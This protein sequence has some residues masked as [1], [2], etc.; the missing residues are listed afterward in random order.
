VERLDEERWSDIHT[1]AYTGLRFDPATGIVEFDYLL[2][3]SGQS[4]SFTD[5]ITFPVPARLPEPDALVTFH[6]V[7]Q[8]LYV[9]VGTIYY[10]SVAPPAVELR[11]VRLTPAASRWAR[12]LY[13]QGLA[14]FAYRW[15]LPHVLELDLI[16]QSA[17]P[18]DHRRDLAVAGRAPLVA[19]GGGKDS[20]VSLEAMRAAGLRPATFA[21]QRQPT[22]LLS[23]LMALAGGPALLVNR[24]QDPRL[25]ALLR[26][27]SVRIGHVP[28]T[29]INS[30]I[31]AA[32]A[33]LHGLGPVVMSN[34]RSADEGNLRWQG[35]EVNHQWSKGEVAEALLRDALDEHAGLANGCFSLLRGM[36]ELHIAQ[37]FATTT[38]YDTVVTSCN[39]AFRMSH[40]GRGGRWCHDCAKC[41]F[42]FL[43]LAPFLARARLVGIFGQ[44]LLDDTR[45]IHGY[46]ELLG[47]TGHKPFECVGEIAECRVAAELLAENPQ[48]ASARVV[49]ELAR[50]MRRPP[51]RQPPPAAVTEVFTARPPRFV[52]PVYAA[53]L[54]AMQAAASAP[55]SADA[56]AALR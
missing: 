11:A 46:R 24:A 51:A 19:I 25:T 14:E 4:L 47:L 6:R 39:Y 21:V 18:P 22:P 52:P 55:T 37:L 54:A 42:T 17:P 29:A 40:Q 5:A 28:V 27:N 13:R 32:A 16:G 48:W 10:K 41:R 44:N 8:L 2:R 43:A 50:E 38:G 49:A 34:E 15:N 3:G 26:S 53:A 35:H 30:L 1:F 45:H 33:A 31:G 36:S 20:I 23:E 9:A 12:Q 7:L 56:G